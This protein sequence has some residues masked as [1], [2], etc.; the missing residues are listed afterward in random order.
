MKK[1]LYADNPVVNFGEKTRRFFMFEEK[2]NS[3][4]KIFASIWSVF[5]GILAASIIYW[6]IGTTGDNPQNT[7][8]F[9]FV[10]YIFRFSSTESNR[11]T[12][13]LYFLFFAFSGLAISIG[14]KSGLFNIGVSGQMTFPAIIFFAIIIGL[15]LD[16]ENISLEFLIGMFFVFIIM[17]MFIGL[18][19]GFLKAFFNVHEVISTIFLNW[20]ITY[21]A[22]YLFTQ[23][24]E[25]FGKESFSYFDPV[26]GTKNIFISSEYQNLF[27]YFGIGLIIALVIFVW[28][29]YSKTAIGYKI[30]MVGLNKTNAKY[31]GINEKLLVVSIMGISGALSGIAGFFL[32]ILKNNKL[33]A[34]SAPMAIGFEAIAIALIALN[35]PIGV[36][37]TSIFYSLINTAQIGFSFLRGSE[38][39]TFDFFPIITGIIIFMSALAII[40]YKFRV[41]RSLVKYGYLSTNKTYWYNFKVY[42]S[43]KFKYILP[44]KL[45]LFKLYFAN[46]KTRLNFRKQESLY[47]KEVYN[48]IKASKNMNEE[49][50]LNFYTK[51]SKAKFEHIAK[52]ND[53]G[54]NNYRDS[55]N[56]FKN[57]V[58]NRKQNFNLLKETLFLDFN[59]KVLTKYKQA[60]KVKDLATEGGM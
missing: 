26:S 52:R 31:V 28:F 42:H 43:S 53:A 20:I 38:K 18:I 3:R 10:T 4:R 27:I 47:Q 39:V 60:F 9:S 30:K 36:L 24:N 55:K 49:D 51:L 22:K 57:Q 58:Q 13:L 17:G 40:F 16:I 44:E 6:I 35:S 8:I 25:A 15:K 37:F 21:I 7:T 56:K 23:G 14:F 32:I 59:K 45:R 41:I 46:L 54:L 1:G 19:S 2:A 11:S 12:F 29:I 5:F 48:Q 33:E 50:L 34:A